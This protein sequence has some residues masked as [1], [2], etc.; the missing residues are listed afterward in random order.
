MPKLFK[1]QNALKDQWA[2]PKTREKLLEELEQMGYTEKHLDE[3]RN[4]IKANDCDLYDVLSHL[5]FQAE[6]IPR[7]K[8]AQKATVSLSDYSKNQ[9]EFLDFILSKYVEDGHSELS[10]EKLPQL[11]ELRYGGV[12]DA[13]D[14]LGDPK[15][16]K[17]SFEDL[18][19]KL[20]A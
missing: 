12:R 5:A 3:L 17:N 20:Y 11:M 6:L 16:V 4:I 2:N 1:D 9:K 10:S 8:R 13:I 7:T 18:Q 14:K 19:M 15:D